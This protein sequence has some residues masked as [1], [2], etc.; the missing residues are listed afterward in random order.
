MAVFGLFFIYPFVYAIY[1]SFFEWGIL[2]KAPGAIASTQNYRDLYDDPVFHRAL[3]NTFEYALL[4]VPLEMALGLLVALVI[5]AK[6]RGRAFFRSAFYFPSI[7]SSAAITT[8]AIFILNPDGL[9]NKI[10]GS[11]QAWFGDSSTALYSVVGLNAWTTA[12]TVMLFYLAALQSIPTDV[13][14]AAAVDGTG[15]WRTFWRITFPLLKPAHFFV[16]VVFGIGALKVFDQFYI[17][18]ERHGRPGVLD[19][20][21]RASTST[22]RRSRARTSASPPRPAWC[23]SSP[24]SSSRCFSARR[25]DGRRSG[26]APDH[27]RRRAEPFVPARARSEV[28]RRVVALRPAHRDRA[29]LLHAV[30]LDRRRRRSRHCRTPRTSTSSLIRSRRQPGRASGTT[31]DFKRYA[32]NSL[33]L[34]V[35]VTLL[36][37]FLAVARRLRVRAAALPGP[38]GALRARAR[39]R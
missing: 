39:R 22:R 37:L 32:L 29:A 21:R 7:A 16:L 5:N 10:I 31:Y 17:V 14:E 20:E 8:I 4:V 33:F 19:I 27:G 25:S 12:G 13:Y 15:A 3:R 2:G 11:N 28:V 34:A 6:I 24:S 1:I 38:R 18:S 36:N 30:R 9:L 26:D 23:C 35:T